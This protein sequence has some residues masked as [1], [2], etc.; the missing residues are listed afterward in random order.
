MRLLL[1]LL[2]VLPGLNA[3][4]RNRGGDAEACKKGQAEVARQAEAFKGEERFKRLIMT[5]LEQA[6]HEEAEGDADECVEALDH[7]R[8]LLK[9]ES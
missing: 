1:C 5:Y 6:K 9:G 3:A 2:I 4:A 7:A 8:M